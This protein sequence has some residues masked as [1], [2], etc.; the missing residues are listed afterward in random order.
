M[1]VVFVTSPLAHCV[2]WY[3][4]RMQRI[5]EHLP[6]E[7]EICFSIEDV[8]RYAPSADVVILDT[9]YNLRYWRDLEFINSL[10]AFTCLR[11]GDIRGSGSLWESDNVITNLIKFDAFFV[12]SWTLMQRHRSEWIGNTFWTPPCVEAQPQEIAR[13]I[14]V[15]S[16]GIVSTAYPFRIFARGALLHCAEGSS[17]RIDPYLTE[18]TLLVAGKRYKLAVLLNC[19]RFT[20]DLE[21][22]EQALAY[23]YY[24]PRLYELLSRTRISCTGPSIY[25]S[26]V[27]KYFENAACGVVTITTPFTDSE[28]LGFEHG[29]TIWFTDESKFMGDLE[30]LLQRKDLVD[31]MSKG[32]WTLARD[33]HAPTVRA[34]ELYE[35]LS[36][37]TGKS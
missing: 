30:Y 26:P 17:T 37:K 31:K 22:D 10:S 4:T 16:W 18:Y 13:D 11:L 28:P 34:L 20:T 24:G 12:Y 7:T 15:L 1:L 2:T 35:F 9:S 29:R 19:H 6:C 32:A 3:A 23:G 21:M 25:E 14:D 33:R 36:E 27:G 5:I 8:H